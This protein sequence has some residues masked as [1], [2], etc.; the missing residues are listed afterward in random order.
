MSPGAYRLAAAPEGDYLAHGGRDTPMLLQLA[1]SPAAA[2]VLPLD[3]L[4]PERVAIARRLWQAA[5]RGSAPT[6]DSPTADQ[7]RRRKL[8]LRALD[9]YLAGCPYREVAVGLFGRKRVPAASEWRVH[10][11]R[12]RTVRLVQDG[13]ERMRGGYLRLLRPERRDG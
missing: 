10:H 7:L 3:D 6:V 8:I 2:V 5:R 1:K 11:L 9:A 12:S 13:L 4:F